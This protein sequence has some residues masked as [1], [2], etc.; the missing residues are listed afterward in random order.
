MAQPFQ[1][2]GLV[3]RA[4]MMIVHIIIEGNVTFGEFEFFRL[5]RFVIM[6]LVIGW[7][8]KVSILNSL[9]IKLVL[10]YNLPPYEVIDW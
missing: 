6:Q 2:G 5:F 7:R 3:P 1:F 8:Y 9:V 10:L 4:N